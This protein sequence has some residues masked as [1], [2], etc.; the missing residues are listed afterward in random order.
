[1]RSALRLSPILMCT[2]ILIFLFA[3]LSVS[4][5]QD[6]DSCPSALPHRLVDA[7][8]GLIIGDGLRM[9]DNPTLGATLITQLDEGQAFEVLDGPTCADA[10]TWWQIAVDDV[11]GW[12]VQGSDTEYWVDR[13]DTPPEATPDV[14]EGCPPDL[15]LKF[16]EG[17]RIHAVGDKRVNFRDES[18]LDGVALGQLTASNIATVVGDIPT[19]NEDEV[20]WLVDLNGT[21]GWV[22]ESIGDEALIQTHQF[23][24]IAPDL[25]FLTSLIHYS[26]AYNGTRF[27]VT[28]FDND[29]VYVYDTANMDAPILTVPDEPLLYRDH[30]LL[31][32]DGSLLAV[33]YMDETVLWDV[34][35]GEVFATIDT[36]YYVRNIMMIANEDSIL[37]NRLMPSVY[38]VG[39]SDMTTIWQLNGIDDN[40]GMFDWHQDSDQVVA[41]T[42]DRPRKIYL[43]TIGSD[44]AILIDSETPEQD[45]I[46]IRFHPSGE[47]LLLAQS[48]GQLVQ[49]PIN[50]DGKTRI[51]QLDLS[52]NAS[53]ACA[54][55]PDGRF[56]AATYW[57]D[58][59]LWDL[60]TDEELL[61]KG[62]PTGHVNDLQFTNNS[63]QLLS[64][65]FDGQLLV[66]DIGQLLRDMP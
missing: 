44:E 38:L 33:F 60:E 58:I 39:R 2:A 30:F 53:D 16:E 20:W 34:D 62:H 12:V 13:V 22:L 54:V 42:T 48:A 27:A 25:P 64:T 3:N 37:M 21:L 46:C 41:L 26:I 52:R 8:Y 49:V 29:V 51:K 32:A 65:V 59:Y 10:Y 4:H 36:E 63:T 6:E 24:D 17:D 15:T 14:I 35:A 66:W 50:E 43:S 61:L 31:S 47:S 1:M 40:A 55:S 19:C 18:S 9:R 45:V 5:T 57:N 7:D 56:F 23:H 11:T 28:E